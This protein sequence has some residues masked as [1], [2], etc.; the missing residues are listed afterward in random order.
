MHRFW[1]ELVQ[2]QVTVKQKHKHTHTQT[3]I[4]R[5][6]LILR[7]C[8]QSELVQNQVNVRQKHTHIQTN[9]YRVNLIL[10][11]CLVPSKKLKKITHYNLNTYYQYYLVREHQ[12]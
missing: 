7:T 2:N 1:S 11:T 6:D 12:T 10:R 3:S 5:V 8:F 9:N 4:Y